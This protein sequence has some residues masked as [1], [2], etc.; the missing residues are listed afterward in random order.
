MRAMI[1]FYYSDN[2]WWGRSAIKNFIVRDMIKLFE[3]VSDELTP[4]NIQLLERAKEAVRKTSIKRQTKVIRAIY[5]LTNVQGIANTTSSVWI[6]NENANVADYP[7]LN[8]PSTIYDKV[9]KN[10]HIIKRIKQEVKMLND[11]YTK[12][13]ILGEKV[14]NWKWYYVPKVLP[15]DQ[16]DDISE[17]NAGYITPTEYGM[18]TRSNGD[19]DWLDQ[20]QNE[21]AFNFLLVTEE[22]AKNPEIGPLGLG[23]LGTREFKIG[24][25]EREPQYLNFEKSKEQRP[26]QP[27]FVLENLGTDEKPELIY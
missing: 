26:K 12:L 16:W 18:P 15:K 27:K 2:G 25:Y 3:N 8:D 21:N 14:F 5:A 11:A 4:E 17:E 6:K 23:K 13:H 9:W 7:F 20:S 22:D 10:V 1:Q 19:G 24:F